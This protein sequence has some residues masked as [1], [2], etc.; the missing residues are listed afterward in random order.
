MGHFNKSEFDKLGR[1]RRQIDW[2]RRSGVKRFEKSDADNPAYINAMHS[3]LKTLDVI[4]EQLEG[5]RREKPEVC[6]E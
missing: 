4:C 1:A 5:W 3:K 6:H 2:A